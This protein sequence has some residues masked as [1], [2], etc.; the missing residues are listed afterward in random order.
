MVPMLSFTRYGG[1]D[2]LCNC[3]STFVM[4]V[5]MTLTQFQVSLAHPGS[6]WVHA[7]K[8]NIVDG[9]GTVCSILRHV[10]QCFWA[11]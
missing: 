2:R 3:K 7:D 4:E 5:D 11:Y 8:P 1:Y 6:Q 9:C 10:L